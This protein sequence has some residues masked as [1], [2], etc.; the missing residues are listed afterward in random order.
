MARKVPRS[1]PTKLKLIK[2]TP[3][4]R[5]R[6]TVSQKAKYHDPKF[7]QLFSQVVSGVGSEASAILCTRVARATYFRWKKAYR[8]GKSTDKALVA[9]FEG[10]EHAS[11]MHK[12]MVEK[13]LVNS[14]FPD[15]PHLALRWLAAKYPEEYS[16]T[17]ADARVGQSVVVEQPLPTVIVNY[18]PRLLGPAPTEGEHGQ[19]E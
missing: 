1:Q 6:G 15:N 3:G 7:C 19:P 16:Q 17:S 4:K 12:L 18:G 11:G 5:E 10:V 2:R 13:G 9:F 14:F 8:S